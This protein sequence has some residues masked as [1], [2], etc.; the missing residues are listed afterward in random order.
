M[1]IRR[2]VQVLKHCKE[3]KEFIRRKSKK[4]WIEEQE[5]KT[6]NGEDAEIGPSKI[7][8]G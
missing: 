6:C 1:F 7:S 8:C 5:K 4:Q 2:G 3:L